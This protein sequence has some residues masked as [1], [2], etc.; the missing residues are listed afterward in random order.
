MA[1]SPT[2]KDTLDRVKARLAE[3]RKRHG[4]LRTSTPAEASTVI[5]PG[6]LNAGDEAA[7]SWGVDPVE[8]T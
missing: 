4:D 3:L 1:T 2:F 6:D 8:G 7:G 5:W